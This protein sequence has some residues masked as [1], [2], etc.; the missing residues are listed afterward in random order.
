M[1]ISFL[2]QNSSNKYSQYIQ[3]IIAILQ[4]YKSTCIVFIIINYFTLFYITF[5]KLFE[6]NYPL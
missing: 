5:C 2:T 6:K 1:K 4:L 3:S